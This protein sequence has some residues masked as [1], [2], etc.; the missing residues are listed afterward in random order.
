MNRYSV[1]A[2]IFAALF[3]LGF[4]PAAAQDVT[5]TSRD[6]KIEL[7]GTLKSFDGE[8]YS[9]D[10]I[11]GR[12]VLDGQGV[13]CSGPGC[14][15]M[16]AYVAEFTFSGAPGLGEV[17]I[18]AL[19][20]AFAA[21]RGLSLTR[22]VEG[23]GRFRLD[24][25]DAASGRD[26]ARI[27]FHLSTTAEGFADLLADEADIAMA[28]REI[29]PQ[30]AA[31]GA[32]AGLGDLTAPARSRI[33]ALDALVPIVGRGNPVKRVSVERLARML[34]GKITDWP[35]QRAPIAVNQ[36]EKGA[37]LRQAV[38]DQ[39]LAPNGLTLSDGAQTRADD[40]GLADA[41]A[42]DPLALGVA[43][44]SEIGNAVPLSLVGDCGMPLTLD[45]RA[46]KAEDY[47]FSTPLLLYTPARRLPLVA[48][49]FLEFL[50]TPA[51]Q[52]VVRQAG[53]V[54]TRWERTALGA[55]GERF[56][57]AIANAGPEVPLSELQRMV[58]VLRGAER[59]T[60]TFRFRG[61][62]ATLDTQSA[63]NVADLARA[64]ESGR[65]DDRELLFVGFSDGEGDWRV[66]RRIARERAEAVRSAVQKAA[67]T[68][69]PSRIDLR[70]EAFG[71]ALPMA[72]DDTNW[73]RR[74]N[75]RV[76]VWLR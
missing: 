69:D 39:I 57:N 23:A 74:V 26:V 37:G 43:R 75:R 6:G 8:F 10:T 32:E 52:R 25:R 67:F 1:S 28:V 5:L 18:P 19:I 36:R 54:D 47:P 16:D 42:Q 62:S 63:G 29:R 72:C 46:L 59:L 60:T 17:L 66:N 44:F 12:L 41:V 45:R 7:S 64:L 50:T 22:V 68:A 11:Y 76:E 15:D 58:K 24:L 71:E 20:E 34:S 48:R 40:A 53:F 70:L 9:I 2:A 56:A 33:V 49:E 55:Q 30:E 14:P 21:Q 13:L 35:E 31:L 3:I 73:G 65:F 38:E 51:A 27:G 61:G 4:S